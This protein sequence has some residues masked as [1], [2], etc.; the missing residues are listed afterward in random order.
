[1]APGPPR[2]KAEANHES[3]HH[4]GADPK[5][6]HAHHWPEATSV[7]MLVPE[8]AAVRYHHRN[9][10]CP[11]VSPT[12]SLA[13][14]PWTC[15][16]ARPMA[17]ASGCALTPMLLL[18]VLSVASQLPLRVL[19]PHPGSPAISIDWTASTVSSRR[20]EH[21]VAQKGC[22]SCMWVS[23]P[24]RQL[25]VG[26]RALPWVTLPGSLVALAIL[27]VKKPG[28][29]LVDAPPCRCLSTRLVVR[30]VPGNSETMSGSLPGPAGA[31]T[32]SAV[33]L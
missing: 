11:Q 12:S 18:L 20:A 9:Q 25:H 19:L 5:E 3:H 10:Q 32:P 29:R 8:A 26:P 27:D 28:T 6:R 13:P 2:A 1:M 30:K 31:L 24:R 21:P 17:V 16:S 33:A 23:L 22:S 14:R 4:V 15:L 7:L